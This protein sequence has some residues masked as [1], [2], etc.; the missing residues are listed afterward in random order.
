V[1]LLLQFGLGDEFVTEDEVREFLP[2]SAGNN[3]LRVYESGSHFQ[4]FLDPVAR[5]D[6]VA[7]LLNQLSS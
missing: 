6:R 3:L 4:M 2:Y 5:R 7:W 1:R